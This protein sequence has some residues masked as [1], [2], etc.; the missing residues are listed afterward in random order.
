MR[1]M[2]VTAFLG[3]L[4]LFSACQAAKDPASVSVS[5]PA[6]TLDTESGA[7]PASAA[8]ESSKTGDL[9]PIYLAVTQR[10]A[11]SGPPVQPPLQIGAAEF[12]FSSDTGVLWVQPSLFE[13]CWQ[14]TCLLACRAS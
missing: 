6:A 2:I 11:M 8:T 5:A 7:G 10:A 14:R 4:L 1:R 12:R 3:A 13:A 9:M